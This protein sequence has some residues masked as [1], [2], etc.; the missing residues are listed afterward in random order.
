[1]HVHL[2]SRWS[3]GPILEGGC[4]SV[5]KDGDRAHGLRR[6]ANHRGGLQ[7]LPL[8]ATHTE[9]DTSKQLE[10]CYLNYPGVPVLTS[11]ICR[12]LI[13]Q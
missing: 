5:S 13:A 3:P 12:Y 11:N 10:L 8:L 1:M 6:P 9:P 4:R 7:G 2:W